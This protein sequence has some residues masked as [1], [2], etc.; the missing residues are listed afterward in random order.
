MRDEAGGVRG[1][2]EAAEAG[3]E[4]MPAQNVYVPPCF[5][6]AAFEAERDPTRQPL[7]LPPEHCWLAA[8]LDAIGSPVY[9][10]SD[11][12]AALWGT[13]WGQDGKD[14]NQPEHAA[15][16]AYAK[17]FTAQRMPWLIPLFDSARAI[18]MVSPGSYFFGVDN[19][20]G[21]SFD[22]PELRPYTHLVPWATDDDKELTQ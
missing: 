13:E 21:M 5:T 16:L 12:K 19:Y 1:I 17:A 11:R 4:H 22:I 2:A 8:L 6:T 15:Y 20:V 10:D 9:P 3:D 14:D 7:F 18:V